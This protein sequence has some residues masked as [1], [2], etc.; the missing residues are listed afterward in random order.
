MGKSG[1]Y[2][3]G[4]RD[5]DLAGDLE[6]RRAAALLTSAAETPAFLLVFLGL[7]ALRVPLRTDSLRVVGKS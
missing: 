2:L 3:V 1:T 6:E 7:M 4:E 5:L